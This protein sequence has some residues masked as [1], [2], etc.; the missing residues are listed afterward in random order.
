MCAPQVGDQASKHAPKSSGSTPTTP[1][2]ELIVPNRLCLTAL[3]HA[4]AQGAQ[5]SVST[6]IRGYPRANLCPRTLHT[7]TMA[8]MTKN[9]SGDQR[10]WATPLLGCK[11][12]FSCP[13]HDRPPPESTAIQEKRHY[14]L[15]LSIYP[16]ICFPQR[17]VHPFTGVEQEGLGPALILITRHTFGC[18][19]NPKK[20]R[21]FFDAP[22]VP[23]SRVGAHPFPTCSGRRY[24][25]KL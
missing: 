23:H 12:S 3:V 20:C 5:E 11:L 4:V 10:P 24:P 22:R 19:L 13:C 16:I 21:N 2:S 18:H 8:Q 15:V 7:H 14:S 17:W 1:W 6:G 25:E 9:K